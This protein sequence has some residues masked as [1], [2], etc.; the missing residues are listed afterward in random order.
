M[1]NKTSSSSSSGS[2][3]SPVKMEIVT[4]ESP[5]SSKWKKNVLTEVQRIKQNN[6][7]DQNNQLKTLWRQNVTQIKEKKIQSPRKKVYLYCFI[8]EDYRDKYPVLRFPIFLDFFPIF[9]PFSFPFSLNLNVFWRILTS[10]PRYFLKSSIDPVTNSR[11]HT[12][13]CVCRYNLLRSLPLSL[14]RRMLHLPLL[15]E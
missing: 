12:I 5:L 4:E 1:S 15:T 11:Y 6:K 10:V 3:P 7:I 8:F 14:S 2:D 9:F 13:F